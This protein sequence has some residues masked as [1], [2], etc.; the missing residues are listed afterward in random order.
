[1]FEPSST[2]SS[3]SVVIYTCTH[4]HVCHIYIYKCKKKR[5]PGMSTVLLILISGPHSQA[6]ELSSIS[7]ISII[8]YTCV[9]THTHTHT[10][11]CI[12][13]CKNLNVQASKVKLQISKFFVLLQKLLWGCQLVYFIP[14]IVILFLTDNKYQ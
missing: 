9:H 13:I 11:M 6:P 7:L 4:A 5:G 3:I 8:I 2:I 1:M 10:Y 14:I 12:Y